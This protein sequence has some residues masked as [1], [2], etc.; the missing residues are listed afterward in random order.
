LRKTFCIAAILAAACAAPGAG[1]F[2]GPFLYTAAPRYQRASE[3]NRFPQGAAVV[4]VTTAGERRIAP[5]LYASA[6]AT[7][8]FD[9]TRI[10]FAGTTSAGVPWQIWETT[11][12][13]G[14][15]RQLSHCRTDCTHPVYLP[16]GR[17]VF[18]QAS[19][20]GSDIEIADTMGGAPERLTYAPGRR[21]T[22]DV[23]RDGRIL[24]ENDG[25][26]DTVYPDGTGVEALRC[27]HGP[28]RGDARQIASGDVIFNVGGRVARFTAA[29]AS[30]AEVAQPAGDLAGP[31]AEI[32]PGRWL[33]AVRRPKGLFGLYLWTQG[34]RLEPAATPA[35][36]NAIQPVLLRSR[37][38]P[39]DFPS[40]RMETRVNG[41]LLCLDARVTKDKPIPEGVA[42]V[43]VY[44][45]DAAGAPVLLG[46][47]SVAGDGS[48][49]VQ[50]PADKPLRIELVNAAGTTLRAERGWFWMRSGEQRVCVGC[51]AGPERSPE[52]KVP[53]V[54]LRSTLPEKMLGETK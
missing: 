34:G 47:Q 31:V 8:S 53:A 16:D 45:R 35:G 10:L 52:N 30:Q 40:A 7:V 22:D 43:Q 27:D 6:D 49:Y 32:A 3:S 14:T 29:L 44:T 11:A 38:A 20:T 50:L 5:K 9:G 51:H 36:V 46:R 25:E 39:K 1:P 12:A 4:L 21:A 33:I 42:A 13:G 15:P 48:F 23:L 54:L 19:S 17:I 2:I 18:T 37:T 41:N 28:R 24:F 26:L